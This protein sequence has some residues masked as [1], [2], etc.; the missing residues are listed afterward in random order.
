MTVPKR[1]HARVEA[2]H[3]A[4]NVAGYW[5][6]TGQIP[7]DTPVL[8]W[9]LGPVLLGHDGSVEPVERAAA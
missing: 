6:K 7:E 8:H 5:L 4:D 1:R 3:T 9:R 2:R